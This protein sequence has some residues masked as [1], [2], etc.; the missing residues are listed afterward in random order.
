MKR[1]III[2]ICSII[3]IHFLATSWMYQYH[4]HNVDYVDYT[5]KIHNGP[6]PNAT[7]VVIMYDTRSPLVNESRNY[8]FWKWAAMLNYDY[9]RR[10]NYNFIYML[11]E[12]DKTNE[13]SVAS[14]GVNSFNKKIEQCKLQLPHKKAVWR[15]V[16]WCKLLAARCIC[17]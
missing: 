3:V 8:T 4:Q 16:P 17:F 6:N 9:A 15:S 11:D 13:S 10:N 5:E 12:N 7:T 14:D 1:P 2:T